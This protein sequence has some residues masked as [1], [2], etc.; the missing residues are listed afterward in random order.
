[1]NCKAKWQDHTCD[2]V[3]VSKCLNFVGF[4][5]KLWLGMPKLRV[6]IVNPVAFEDIFLPNVP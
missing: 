6:C 1:M 3:G 4:D 5:D 2:L